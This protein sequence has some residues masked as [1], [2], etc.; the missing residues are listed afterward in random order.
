MSKFRMWLVQVYTKIMALFTFSKAVVNTAAKTYILRVHD[1]NPN[2][3]NF[4]IDPT[5][6]DEAVF[7]GV[8]TL[9]PNRRAGEKSLRYSADLGY[10]EV[11]RAIEGQ[12]K[13]TLRTGAV[14]STDTDMIRLLTRA[15]VRQVCWL[16]DDNRVTWKPVYY[17]GTE[18]ELPSPGA[19][20]EYELPF[21]Y[22]QIT[23][24]VEI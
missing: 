18:I 22:S 7:S 15:L 17:D 14:A 5:T 23:L 19:M 12:Q 20:K 8:T 9:T 24:D 2:G 10:F 1:S 11:L 3:I 6:Y 13:I 16:S 21:V 4:D